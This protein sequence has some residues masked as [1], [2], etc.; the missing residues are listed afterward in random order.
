MQMK[1]DP[2]ERA[3]PGPASAGQS[4]RS[5][6]D[7]IGTGPRTGM[8]R[9][10]GTAYWRTRLAGWLKR[11][12]QMLLLTTAI[13]LGAMAAFGARGYIS[14]QIAIERERLQPRQ[15]MVTIVVAKQDLARGETISAQTVAVRE[16][17]RAYLA[18]GTLQPERF[19]G[20]AGARLMAP[21]RA[22]EPLLQS[23][24]E[25]ADVSTFAA[26]VPAGVRAFTVVV[27]EVNSISGMLQPGD[28]ID[29]LLSARLP[30]TPAQPQ[31]PEITRALL[32][33]IKVLATGRQ[34][35]PG[36]DDKSVRTYGAIT[37]EVSP[38]QAQRLVV[39][40]RSGKLTATLRNPLDRDPVAQA[41]LDVYALLGLA[42]PGAPPPPSG[43]MRAP[44][45]P[46]RTAEIIVGGQGSLKPRAAE[47]LSG[48]IGESAAALSPAVPQGAVLSLSPPL[49]SA[50]Q[51]APLLAPPLPTVPGKQP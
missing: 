26:K 46:L 3:D 32:Q 13:G 12:R 6:S 5:A 33:D 29:L 34:V 40:Q 24:L 4:H 16:I 31:P 23:A 1:P 19:E 47:T 9:T 15:P 8:R 44:A 10:R 27:D 20:F 45:G 35:R 36:G 49:P 41:P 42:A 28:R 48:P 51:F 11:R 22:G 30:A 43:P 38:E 25:G 39:A 50:P 21:L 17:P 7:P 37:V 18:P 2:R 14:D